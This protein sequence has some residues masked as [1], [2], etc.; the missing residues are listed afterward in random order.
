MEVSAGVAPI[1]PIPQSPL[2]MNG[3]IGI[4][5]SSCAVGLIWAFWNYLA[6]K[7]VPIGTGSTG[8]YESVVDGP[9]TQ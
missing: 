7:K 2:D 4:V 3:V 6:I 1:S 8:L 9:G 5:I